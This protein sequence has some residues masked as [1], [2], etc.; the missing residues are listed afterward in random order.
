M[1]VFQKI[2]GA[3][4]LSKCLVRFLHILTILKV[5]C[6]ES[7]HSV[8]VYVIQV[9]NSDLNDPQLWIVGSFDFMTEKN[10]YLGWS[11]LCFNF[12]KK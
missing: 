6:L 3:Q 12:P 11:E 5:L 4:Y 2:Y 10:K 8:G 7:G 1:C 9:E